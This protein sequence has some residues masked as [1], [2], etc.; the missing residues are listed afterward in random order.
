[1]NFAFKGDYEICDDKKQG[2]KSVSYDV[3]FITA[4]EQFLLLLF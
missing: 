1:M 3:D 2:G 4:D